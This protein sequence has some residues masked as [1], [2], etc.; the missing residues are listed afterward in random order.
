MSRKELA[1]GAT[2]LYAIFIATISLI[3][4]SEFKEMGSVSFLDKV[5]HFSLYMVL[6]TML[7]ITSSLFRPNQRMMHEVWMTLGAIVFGVLIEFVQ[8]FTGRQCDLCDMVAN[9]IGAFSA[10]IIFNA[11]NLDETIQRRS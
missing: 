4:F 6:N 7:L 10:L 8:S 5:V 1:L 9:S 3:S 11:L 2:I